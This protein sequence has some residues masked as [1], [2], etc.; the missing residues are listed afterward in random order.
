MKIIFKNGIFTRAC[1]TYLI[2]KY[3]LN[4]RIKVHINLGIEFYSANF[5]SQI[6]KDCRLIN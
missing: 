1:I 3:I 4:I 5:D 2:Y 6:I